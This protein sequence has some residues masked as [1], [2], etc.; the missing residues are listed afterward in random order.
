MIAIGATI[1]SGIFLT[2][3]IIA[4]ALPSP[5]WILAMWV[6]GGLMALAG[7]LT[8]AELGAMMPRSGGLYVFLTEA[9]GGLFGFLFGWAYFW[10]VNTGS[11]AA[12]AVAF[13]YYLGFFLP[14]SP[15]E[16]RLISIAAL[17]FVTVINVLGVK[18]GGIFS[19]VFTVLK[20]SGLIGVI[21]V[22][23][24]MGSS[25]TTDFS[26][27]FEASTRSLTSAL[28]LALV[29]VLWSYGGWQHATFA[30]AE[31]KDPLTTVPRSL[32]LGALVII[33][34]YISANV[35]YMFLLTPAQMASSTRIAA[36][37]VSVALGAVGGS[38]ISAT[39][40][41]STF[42]TTGTYTLSGPRIYYAMARDGAFFRKVANVHPRFRTPAYA[43]VYQSLWAIVLILFWGTFENLIS[44]VVFTDW[45]FFGLTGASIFIFRKRLPDTER[46]YKTPWY[47]L[48]PLFFVAISLW[49][50]LNT[51][52]E[53]PA[54]AWAGI[55]FL[56]LGIPIYYFWKR[57]NKGSVENVAGTSVEDG[58]HSA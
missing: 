39:I 35:A 24:V 50:V 19:D 12:L 49:F 25:S 26:L 34:T 17:I 29:G 57:A 20:L 33:L 31:A 43:I 41:I 44:Y 51:L 56:A 53:K 14:L 3:S 15:D 10:V 23:L 7:A 9:Y 5:L 6:I 48:T 47:P 30:A 36:D 40:V 1:G 28:T 58:T 54:E 21:F 13:S 22:G 27:S 8:F 16:L 32:I 4:Q 38:L 2:P 11:L 52:I 18:A 37:A 45:I 42:G 55:G 46:P